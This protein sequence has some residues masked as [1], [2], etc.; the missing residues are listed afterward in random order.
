[1]IDSPCTT[2]Y[3]GTLIDGTEF[4]SSYKHGEPLSFAPNEMIK[5]WTEAMQLM[6]EG[7]IWELY[8]PPELAYGDDGVEDFIP[9][10]AVLIFSLE[11]IEVQGDFVQS[12]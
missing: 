12:S 1:M 7:S 3:T 2:H 5:G 4:E 10:G 8:V 9:G 11:L 6:K